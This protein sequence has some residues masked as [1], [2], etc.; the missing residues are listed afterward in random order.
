MAQY[1]KIT[2]RSANER[3]EAAIPRLLRVSPR[4]KN[5]RQAIAAAIRLESLGRLKNN[6]TTIAPAA[7]GGLVGS[8]G[9]A[10]R[11]LAKVGIPGVTITRARPA[12]TRTYTNAIGYADT[13][14]K[15]KR[16]RRMKPPK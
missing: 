1:I 5:K 9:Q 15:S 10:A 8:A 6:G 12:K 14:R 16:D 4:V 2:G 7:K 11:A 13:L 3:I